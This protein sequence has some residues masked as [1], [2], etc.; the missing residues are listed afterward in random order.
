MATEWQWDDTL[1]AGTAQY[2]RRGRLPYAPGL[3]AM[4][5]EALSLDG[6]GRLLDVGCGPG[7]IAVGLAHLFGEAVGLDPDPG[8]IA[9]ARRWA[10]EAGVADKTSWTQARAEELPVGLGMFTAVTFGQAFHWME[11]D[12]VAATVRDMLRP[13]GAVLHISDVKPKDAY[14][15]PSVEGLPH[16]EVPHAAVTELVTDYLGPVRRA[17]KGILPHGTQD[18]EAAVF[19]RAG[20]LSPEHHIVPGG[21]PLERATDD[22][23]AGVFSMSLSAPHQFGNR[24]D[25]F[26]ADLRRLLH[27]ASPDGVFSERQP[28][29]EIFVWRKS[30]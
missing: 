17:G 14:E 5:A 24:R 1:F 8:M 22:I 28:A 10:E 3:A 18:D 7:T 4:L 29:T 16:P 19:T 27:E 9:E 12:V 25:E 15:R 21:Q 13:G 23:V 26:E 6:R 2:Y 11:R 20:F 30:A